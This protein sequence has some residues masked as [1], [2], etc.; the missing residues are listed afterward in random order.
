MRCFR[1]KI[2][3]AVFLTDPAGFPKTCVFLSYSKKKSY[4]HRRWLVITQPSFNYST[5]YITHR[6]KRH[7]PSARVLETVI[8][9]YR[10]ELGVPTPTG[11][12]NELFQN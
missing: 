3:Y 7:V 11:G 6:F 4:A 12:L 8:D 1:L 10:R 9:K 5:E 2:I